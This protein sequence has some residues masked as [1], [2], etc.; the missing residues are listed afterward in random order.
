MPIRSGGSGLLHDHR[1]GVGFIKQAKFARAFGIAGISRVHEDAAAHQNAV[2][3]S[4]HRGNPT[5]VEVLAAGAVLASQKFADVALYGLLP[6]AL[7]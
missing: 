3:F 4:H 5:H 1:H 7:I 2:H 6:E